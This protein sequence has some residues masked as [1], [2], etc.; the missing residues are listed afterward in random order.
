M[1]LNAACKPLQAASVHAKQH[2]RTPYARHPNTPHRQDEFTMLMPNQET[3]LLPMPS[4]CR[5]KLTLFMARP[6]MQFGTEQ[7]VNCRLQAAY[8]C[9]H[10]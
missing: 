1:H 9:N 3:A 7:S 2:T 6:T 8:S 10:I 4:L 5:T